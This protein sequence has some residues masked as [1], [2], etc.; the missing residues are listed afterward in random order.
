MTDA[1]SLTSFIVASATAAI[2]ILSTLF[3]AFSD[4]KNKRQRRTGAQQ[5]KSDEEGAALPSGQAAAPPIKTITIGALL[6]IAAIASIGLAVIDRDWLGLLTCIGFAVAL[7]CWFLMLYAP[8]ICGVTTARG[9][10]CRR[11]TRGVLFGCHLHIW[12]KFF[13]RLGWRM[14]PTGQTGF[15]EGANDSVNLQ[16]MR[17][18]EPRR[19]TLLFYIALA[20]TLLALVSVAL[21]VLG[22]VRYGRQ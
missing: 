11:L 6:E 14:Q 1:L 5:E 4:S 16:R 7:P 17:V 12:I 9:E 15:V 19:N 18:S 10:P 22:D 20:F 2:G 8:S 13:I 21:D 3:V